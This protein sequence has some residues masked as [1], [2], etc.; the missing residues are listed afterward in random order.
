MLVFVI[1]K[2]GTPLMPCSPR[3]ARILLKQGKAKVIKTE[4]FTIKLLYGSSGYKQELTLGIDSGSDIIGSAVSDDEGNIVY[5]SEVKVRNDITD[6][7]KRRA[8]YRRN[9]RFRKTR[10]RPARWLN[11]KNSLRKDRFSPTMTSK[12]NSHLKEINYVKKILP[13]KRIIIE[14]GSFDP[15]ALKNPEVL[16]NKELYQ[17]GI[18]YGF[19]NT[20][21]YVLDRDG[22][23]CQYCKGK[24]KEKGLHVHHI[25]YRR[26]KGSD[27]EGNLLTL[28]K[29]CHDKVHSGEIVL[30]NKGKKKSLLKHA[31]QMNSVRI[32]LL[33]RIPEAEETFGYITKINRE[34]IGLEKKHYIDASVISS[35]GRELKFKNDSVLLKR[36]VSDGDYRQTRGIRSE[37]RIPAGKLMG[38][39]KFDKIKYNGKEY[40]IKGRMSRGY[41]NLMGID[42][43]EIKMKPIAKM[44]RIKRINSR[45][46]WIIYST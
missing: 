19:K 45:K 25:I 1:S 31:T 7:M 33:K 41:C 29:Q 39:R 11:R 30:K 27:E 21:A 43:K 20:K 3:N 10:Y 18:N 22:Y 37:Q 46:T 38:F 26:D 35:C 42:N 17:K 9:R 34:A 28:C 2:K 13:I 44:E 8:M 4:P 32:Q 40:F 23:K 15:H 24:S 5:S 6:K 12:I 14:T 36:C 16:N